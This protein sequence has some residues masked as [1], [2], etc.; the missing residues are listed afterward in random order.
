[1]A[2]YSPNDMLQ[3][4][5][6]LADTR[7][8]EKMSLKYCREDFKSYYGAYPV[9]F[10]ALWED[11]LTSDDDEVR[12]DPEQASIDYFYMAIYYLRHYNTQ[13]SL[14]AMFGKSDRSV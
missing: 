10:A 3:I 8:K 4:G 7:S 1:M 5:L 6:N 12:L 14:G 13:K 9:V 2:I 11:L